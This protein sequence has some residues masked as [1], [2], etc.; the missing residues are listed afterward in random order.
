MKNWFAFENKADG[1]INI[2]VHDEIGLWGVSAREFISELRGY[3]DVKV[4]NLSIHSPGG[5]L[6]D[7]L[8]IYNVLNDHPAKVYGHVEGIA[9]SAA[10]FV[11]M[12]A[13]VI[14]MPEDAFIM[15][16]NAWALAMGDSD[17]MRDVADVLDK[18]QA[19]ALNIYE[20]R[21]GMDRAELA[22]MMKAETWMNSSEALEYGF[23]D[24]ISEPIQAAAKINIFAKYFKSMPV[25]SPRVEVDDIESV[26]DFEKYL[27]DAGLSKGLAQ[28][29]T[30]RAKAV[31]PGEP[32]EPD[33]A[34]ARVSE[35]L[36]KAKIPAQISEP[37]AG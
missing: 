20:R 34:L 12:A 29:L 13:D 7:G 8:A 16:H 17:E 36:D 21:T 22:T 15:I 6:L 4:I 10:S 2:S 18:M 30:S 9:A 24:T 28:A 23:I 37:D 32:G 14:S 25:Q 3:D 33:D 31:F 1:V 11:L 5:S 19:S 27:R 26:T 35:A